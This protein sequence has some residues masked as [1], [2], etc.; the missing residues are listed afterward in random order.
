MVVLED[1]VGGVQLLSKEHNLCV[2]VSQMTGKELMCEV[3]KF[4]LHHSK[5]E[6]M[7]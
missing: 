1:I 3:T 6:G 7:C 2:F 4:C 5:Y